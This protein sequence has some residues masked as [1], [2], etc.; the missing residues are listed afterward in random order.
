MQLTKTQKL[1]QKKNHKKKN[2]HQ[3]SVIEEVRPVCERI[4][5]P[6]D[7]GPIEQLGHGGLGVICGYKYISKNDLNLKFDNQ[8]L[9][10]RNT[11]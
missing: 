7:R 8:K 5:E 9:K 1:N 2:T 11:E 6:T 4:K 10:K 3:H